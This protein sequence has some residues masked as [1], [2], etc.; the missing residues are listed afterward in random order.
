MEDLAEIFTMNLKDPLPEWKLSQYN[1]DR[2]HR[3]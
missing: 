1:G 2:I 3:H